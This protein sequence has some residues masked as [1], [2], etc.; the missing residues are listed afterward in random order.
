MN[1]HVS[2]LDSQQPRQ[3]LLT[4]MTTATLK[5]GADIHE[6]RQ[7]GY[8][9]QNF[10]HQWLFV[11]WTIH[12]IYL[13]LFCWYHLHYKSLKQVNVNWHRASLG[14]RISHWA[15]GNRDVMLPSGNSSVLFLA[16][17]KSHHFQRS[18]TRPR[19]L[20]PQIL[21]QQNN[22]TEC[23]FC[24]GVLPAG[25]CQASR[26]QPWCWAGSEALNVVVDVHHLE[27]SPGLHGTNSLRYEHRTVH[28]TNGR[29]TY[30]TGTNYSY[31]M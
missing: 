15:D 25:R 11:P 2:T 20:F 9:L 10:S 22:T 16:S 31:H 30:G 21:L 27:T 7:N 5:P 23:A 13:V 1:N 17:H 6:H 18:W 19:P 12:T 4:G 24:E 26:N 28:V 8:W 3:F 14:H 29:S